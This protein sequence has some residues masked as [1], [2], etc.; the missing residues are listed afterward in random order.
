MEFEDSN[1]KIGQLDTLYYERAYEEPI[2]TVNGGNMR[3][4]AD[5]EGN[6]KIDQCFGDYRTNVDDDY[7]EMVPKRAWS[8]PIFIDYR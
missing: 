6:T 4:T 3:A 5:K 8:S 1:Y 2:P 7:L